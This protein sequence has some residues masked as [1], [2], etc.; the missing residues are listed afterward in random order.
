VDQ[1]D[2]AVSCGA[3]SVTQGERVSRRAAVL[4]VGKARYIGYIE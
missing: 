2:V 1:A 3:S 4:Y